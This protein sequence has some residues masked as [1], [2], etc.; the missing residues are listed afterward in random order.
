MKRL[1]NILTHIAA[2]HIKIAAIFNNKLKLGVQGRDE[3]FS[4]LKNKIS[5][6]DQVIWF[7]CASLGEYEQGLPVFEEI[8]ASQPNHKIVLSFFSPSGFEIRKNSPIADCVVY[9]PLDTKQNAKQFLDLIQPELIVFV[10]YEI[11]P[12]YL[13]E[14]NKR[15][16]HA[17][18]ISALFRKNQSFFKASGKWM[19]E[20]LF[21][22]KHIF[23]QNETSKK[24]LNTIGYHEVTVS[25]DT[26]FDRVSNQLKINNK[27][28]FIETFK[29]NKLCIVAGSTWPEDEAL[30]INSIN[31]DSSN[32]KY[33]IAP[34]NIKSGQ[35]SSL[36]NKLNKLAILYSEKDSVDL[37]KAKVFI[38][39]TIGILSKIY[40][41]SDIAYVGGAM[42]STGLHNTLEP[43]VFGVPIII[44]GNH[45]KFPE[46]KA[47]IDNKGMFSIENQTEF[48]SILNRLI[49]NDDLRIKSGEFNAN[50]IS[51]NKGAVAQI[52][53]YLN[54]R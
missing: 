28:H 7:H 42:G 38:I 40:S 3:T 10:K 17:I 48:D 5:D 34:H 12:N 1:Y 43:A 54:K 22:F 29:Q 11:W 36:K 9:L 46:A 16:I 18:L 32:T 24:L 20:A 31:N 21:A 35:I 6:K 51:K 2:F 4:V 37:T 45:E 13:L 47:M 25:G 14:I 15:Q 19:Q 33:I 27:L 49:K 50:Y 23:V 26:R 44:G 8:R 52:L 41:Y 39:D 30:F 53:T